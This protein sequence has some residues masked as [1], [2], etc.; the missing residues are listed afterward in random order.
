MRTLA[1]RPH[2]R[3]VHIK[4]RV[5]KGTP[6]NKRKKNLLQKKRNMS[7]SFQECHQRSLLFS[8]CRRHHKHKYNTEPRGHLA[9]KAAS[10]EEEER[11]REKKTASRKHIHCVCPERYKRKQHAKAKELFY[12]SKVFF[13]FA[14]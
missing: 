1:P 14:S 13:F 8:S 9:Y 3:K 7:G 11:E 6:K 5:K 2:L 4:Q 12:I 10:K